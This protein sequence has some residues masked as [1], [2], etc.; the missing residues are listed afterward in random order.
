MF[1]ANTQVTLFYVILSFF[2]CM[3]SVLLV[4]FRPTQYN[5]SIKFFGVS[6]MLL[7]CIFFIG[8]R[9]WWNEDVFIDSIRYAEFYIEYLTGKSLDLEAA[10]DLGFDVLMALCSRIGFSVDIYFLICAFLYVYPLYLVAKKLSRRYDFLFFLMIISAM[11]FYGYGVN[12]IRNGIATSF[13]MLAFVEYKNTYKFFLLGVLGIL[14]HKSVI[15]PFVTF[16]I[17]MKYTNVKL[18]LILWVLSIPASFVVSNLLTDVLM[19]ISFIADRADGYLNEA[20]DSSTFSHVGFR[21]DFLIYGAMPIALGLYFIYKKSF[22]DLFYERLFSCYMLS[23]SFWILINQVSYSNRFAYLSWFMMPV[24]LVYPF[25]YSSYMNYRFSKIA[26]LL[27][28]HIMFTI[29]I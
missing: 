4:M 28:L 6:I 7:F 24:L 10:R 25:I 20:A 13:I 12:G 18:Y 23:N 19:G 9:E 26:L 29:V 21:Y 15:L 22:K 3:T 5:V 8:Y 17:S 2:V 27:V 14:F 16:I 1:E 11:S